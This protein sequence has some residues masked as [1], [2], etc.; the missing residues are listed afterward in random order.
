MDRRCTIGD[1]ATVKMLAGLIFL[2]LATLPAWAQAAP[3]PQQPQEA[4]KT[5]DPADSPRLVPGAK[6]T[7]DL[8]SDLRGQAAAFPIGKRDLNLMALVYVPSHY[9]STRP[10]PV[11]VDGTE[12]RGLPLSLGWFRDEAEKHGFILVSIEYLYHQGQEGTRHE[13]WTRR[14]EGS[15]R[16]YSRTIPE[17]LAD[18]TVDEQHVTAL[19][20]DLKRKY[21]VEQRTVGATGFLGAG[22]MAYRLP[23][24]YPKLF[25]TSIVRSGG[26]TQLLMPTAY[27]GALDLPFHIIYGEKETAITLEGTEQAQIFLKSNHFKKI[28]AEKIPNS[29]VDARPDIAANYFRSTIDTLLGAERA[30]FDRAA[31]RAGRLL[32]GRNDLDKPSATASPPSPAEVAA[33]L[34]GFL[35]KYPAA[36]FRGHARFLQARVTLEKLNDP[37]KGEEMLREF[38]RSP[39]LESEAAPAA[40]L[41]LGQRLAADTRTGEAERWLRV[42]IARRATPDDLRARATAA[43]AE[44]TPKTE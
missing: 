33:G 28:I 24:A 36:R 37:Q 29:G 19:L 3:A 20:T 38:T 43:L 21:T 14:G 15:I 1:M 34:Q 32:S 5:S 2:L 10:W 18:M 42:V 31:H 13:V 44:L 35:D 8:P 41:C 26:F 9:D 40:L 27:A 30:A 39:L 4:P 23:M 25:C 6:V 17:I 22:L 12:R 16:Q 11:L 7:A